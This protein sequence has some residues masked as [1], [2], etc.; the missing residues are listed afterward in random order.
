[1]GHRLFFLLSSFHVSFSRVFRR[2]VKITFLASPSSNLHTQQLTTRTNRRTHQQT[3]T[4]TSKHQLTPANKR[5]F[6]RH[7]SSSSTL[8]TGNPRNRDVATRLFFSTNTHQLSFACVC[9]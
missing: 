9:G 6:I 1:M 4:R 2:A 7:S 8:T 3:P 5:Q